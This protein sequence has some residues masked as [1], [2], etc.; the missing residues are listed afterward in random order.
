MDICTELSAGGPRKKRYVPSVTLCFATWVTAFLLSALVVH[1]GEDRLLSLRKVLGNPSFRHSGT[2]THI[3]SLSDGKTILSSAQDGTARLWDIGTGEEIQRLYH[4][5]GSS[6]WHVYPVPGKREVL[7]AGD[8]KQVT[9]WDLESGKVIRSFDHEKTVFRVA[10]S[11]HT[12]T[13]AGVDAA[14]KCVVWNMA[15]GA[16]VRTLVGHGDS[17]Y[18][19]YFSSEGNA[20]TTGCDDKWIRVWNLATGGVEKSFGNDSGSIFTLVPSPCGTKVLVCCEKRSVWAYEE[21]T[22]RQIWQGVLPERVHCAAWSPD[23]KHVAALCRNSHLYVLDAAGGVEKFKVELPA[24]KHYAVAYSPDGNEIIC[25]S[26]VLMCRFDASN[27]KRVF[28]VSGAP[29]QQAPV[30]SMAFLKNPA[31]V[32]CPGI[33][34]VVIRSMTEDSLPEVWLEN[35]QISRVACSPDS[36]LIAAAGKDGIV[37]LVDAM[38]GES[39]REL[40]HGQPITALAFTADGA[41]LVSLGR[42]RNAVVWDVENGSSKL[43]FKAHNSSV[44]DLIVGPGDAWIA[45][46]SSDKSL[47]ISDAQ[48]GKVIDT[49]FSGAGSLRSCDVSFAEGESIIAS[50]GKTIFLWRTP[51]VVTDKPTETEINDLVEQLGAASYKDRRAASARLG[52]LG[53]S[54]LEVIRR[55]KTDDPEVSHRLKQIGE[56]ILQ[57]LRYDHNAMKLECEKELSCVAFHPTGSHWLAI[58]GKDVQ[59]TVLVGDVHN[60]ELRVTGRVTDPNGP[61]SISFVDRDT[62][63]TGNG[64]GT[65]SVYSFQSSSKKE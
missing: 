42:G 16:P 36:K 7:T 59:S 60:N 14:N 13:V 33:K 63:V 2:I 54:A 3:E 49:L 29:W 11:P 62:V 6:V 38:S 40:S 65:L 5:G 12:N 61:V 19:A 23:G 41:R 48:T 34:G 43:S 57:S 4:P 39:V 52:Q 37:R 8:N 55:V 64:N 15:N 21:K 28:P 45:T 35:Q 50:G 56:T 58:E 18:T 30:Q 31:R 17:V 32:V 9:H 22:R 27:G 46:A 24:G 26:D 20:L 10:V 53:R 1:A 47:R 25:S 51:P 44:N